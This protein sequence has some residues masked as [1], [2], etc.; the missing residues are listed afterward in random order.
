VVEFGDK[1][2]AK[3]LL[4]GGQSGDPTSA[5]FY[6]QAKRYAERQFKDVAFYK[7]DVLERAVER[8]RPGNRE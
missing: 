5:H 2:K 3:S 1:V 4:A 6:D 7:D 8:Y